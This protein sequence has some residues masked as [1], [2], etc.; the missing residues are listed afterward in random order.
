MKKLFFTILL[1]FLLQTLHAQAQEKPYLI[2]KFNASTIKELEVQTSGG[3]IHVI[4]GDRAEAIVE[5][6]VKSNNG[7]SLSKSEIESRLSKYE[8]TISQ[9]GNTL[10]C[11]AKNKE[12]MGWRNGLSITFKLFTPH[13]INTE[14]LT[15]G[16][17]INLK[18]LKGEL[19]FT[20]SGGGLDLTELA[21]SV[22]GRTSGGGIKI[23]NSKAQFIDLSTSGGGIQAST[24][25]GDIKLHTSGGGIKL[26]DMY[27]M[28]RAH[29]SGGGVSV[30]NLDGELNTSTS[31]GSIH[32]AQIKGSVKASTSGGGINAKIDKMGEYL[33]LQ[34]SGGNIDVD[35]P[36]DKGMDIDIKGNR[37]TMNGYKDFTGSF[38]KDHVRGTLRGGG[39]DVKISTSSGN[40]NIN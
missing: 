13:N 15:S 28:V 32:L 17:G 10:V 27:G 35:M 36:M 33:S 23:S 2:K 8:F 7:Q 24:L 16:G 34:S 20:T 26:N 18:N 21:G 38:Q 40:V 1:G 30:D 3:G 39:V 31:G 9:K 14:L 37:V 25:S 12:K 19:N 11:F 5:V 29:T 6:Y 4:G 22:K